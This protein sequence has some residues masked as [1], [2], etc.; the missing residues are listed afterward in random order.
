MGPLV[1]KPLHASPFAKK[2]RERGGVKD[3][4]SSLLSRNLRWKGCAAGVLCAD[5]LRDC[6]FNFIYIVAR[7]YLLRHIIH[8]YKCTRGLFVL[9]NVFNGSKL[10]AL[11]QLDFHVN[12]SIAMREFP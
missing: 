6:S 3:A 5:V 12:R 10:L 7:L 1:S 8:C 2:R 9:V 4:C 11:V